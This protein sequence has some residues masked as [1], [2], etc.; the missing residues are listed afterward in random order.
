MYFLLRSLCTPAGLAFPFPGSDASIRSGH[1]PSSS[2]PSMYP[3]Q[4]RE[5]GLP[6]PGK[7]V[8]FSSSLNLTYG[9]FLGVTKESMVF[10]IVSGRIEF[11]SVASVHVRMNFSVYFFCFPFLS[12]HSCVYWPVSLDQHFPHDFTDGF[13]FFSCK[14][15]LCIF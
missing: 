2:V 3:W 12:D 1:T 7:I 14:C 4:S 6:G 10:Y 9:R 5:C 13:Y 11:N 15:S 8:H